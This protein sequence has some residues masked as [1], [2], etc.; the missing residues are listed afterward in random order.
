MY[1]YT[2]FLSMKYS[3]MNFFK[4]SILISLLSFNLGEC[5]FSDDFGWESVK[6]DSFYDISEFKL[7]LY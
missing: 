3:V 6:S 1:D 2:V 7:A 5:K 4:D